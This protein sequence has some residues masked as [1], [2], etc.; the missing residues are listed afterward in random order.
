MTT[1][2]SSARAVT[3]P[4][5]P[6]ID[7][8]EDKWAR[9]WAEQGTYTLRPVAAAASEIYSIDTP[10]PTVSGSLHIG[11]VFSLHPHRLHRPLP[12]D[13]RLRGL[14]PDGL[15]RQRPADRA[16]GAELL[17]RALRRR[18]C[19][20]TPTSSR[21]SR[22]A[23]ARAPRPPTRCRSAGATSSSCASSLTVEDEKAFEEL[24]R[25]ARALASTG[26]S[27]YR[28]IDDQLA[29]DRASRR[30]CATSRRGE[31]YQAEAPDLWDVTFQTAVAQAELEARDYPGAYHRV[32]FHRP[33]GSAGRTSR[34]PA[35]S[36]SRPASPWSPTP[37]TSATSRLFGT[38]VTS[39][40]FGVEVPV[41]R[42]PPG[43][44]RQGRRHRDVLH[45]RRPHRR[46]VVARAAAADPRRSSAATAGSSRETPEWITAEPG[47]DAVRRAR[48]QD[49]VLRA[50]RRW[51]SCCASP[52]TWTASRRPTQR[53][54]KFYEKGDKPL[55]IV[56]IAPVVHP[57]R[58]PRR[59]PARRS[60]SRAATS[61]T[62]TPRSCASA[63]RTGSAASTATG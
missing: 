22:A 36:C 7:G 40:L 59:R 5:K 39:P 53:T 44:A 6:S 48:R 18:R 43:R 16:P 32:A 8:L 35:P 27:D 25:T 38:T 15:G 63:T 10:P 46:A 60:C 9:V 51:S 12:A 29:G 3:M 17:R 20:T 31:A 58:R 56:T 57:Q 24:F 45:L 19:P 42:P 54:V 52:A 37:T 41:A 49:D 34:P 1:P 11:H 23:T 4:D 61:S 50:R 62:S 55:E 14:L 21:R 28:T 47:R 13:A 33:D 26:T 2:A 30:S